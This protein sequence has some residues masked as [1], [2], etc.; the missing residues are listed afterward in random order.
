MVYNTT[1]P[2]RSQTRTLSRGELGG[3][4]WV[5]VIALLVSF[6]SCKP[7]NIQDGTA[8][9]YFDLAGYFKADTAKLHKLN[10]QTIK[11]VIHN[12]IRETKTV[13]I[14]DWGLELSLFIQ[15]DINK[16]AWRDSYSVENG[17]YGS[18]VYTAKTPELK[19]REVVINRNK[20]KSIKWIMIYNASKN[21]LYNTSEV[22]A[23]IP[24]SIY[25]IKKMQHVRLL[26]TNNYFIRGSLN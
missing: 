19:T 4:A 5:I 15:S 26:G 25:T 24:D 8:P 22:L 3:T 1:R 6:S 11:T 23:Y 20:D 2:S 10:H 16:P 12:G 18:V 13:H 17:A 9:K 7:E 21:I 14:D